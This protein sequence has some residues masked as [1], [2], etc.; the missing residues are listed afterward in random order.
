[1]IRGKWKTMNNLILTKSTGTT[2]SLEKLPTG[3]VF[4]DNS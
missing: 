2:N 4:H 1:M 3:G